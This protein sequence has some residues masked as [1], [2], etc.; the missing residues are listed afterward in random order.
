MGNCKGN[1]QCSDL[2]FLKDSCRLASDFHV[3]HS[4]V[5]ISFALIRSLLE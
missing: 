1:N 3:V 2:S 4:V 5:G